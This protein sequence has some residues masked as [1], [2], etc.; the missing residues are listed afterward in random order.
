MA[1]RVEGSAARSAMPRGAQFLWWRACRSF[2][3]ASNSAASSGAISLALKCIAD[4]SIECIIKTAFMEYIQHRRT[5]L[6]V[7]ASIPTCVARPLR[8]NSRCFLSLNSVLI[9]N[10][11]PWPDF[12]KL[13][14][15]VGFPGTDVMLDG[16]MKAGVPATR[17][18]LAE[19]KLKP[20]IFDFPTEFRK[21]DATFSA[22]LPKLKQAAAFASAIGCPRMMT[23]IMSSS[24]IPERGT[25]RHVPEAFYRS[26]THS[27]RI[28]TCG[29]GLE[30]LGP[31]HIRKA[32]SA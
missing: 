15:K 4:N 18:L 11:V 9:Q 31:L 14:A 6:P 21:D 12:A 26:G 25:A 28:T 29:W 5:F 16:A 10:R 22:G 20:A 1:T 19:L 30:F 27:G 32:V 24:P 3:G 2:R 8:R 17:D 7:L 23:Y 13:A